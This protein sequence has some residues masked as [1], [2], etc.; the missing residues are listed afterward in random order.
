MTNEVIQNIIT[1]RSIKQYKAQQITDE[2][3]QT[4]LEAG[5]YAPSG[6]GMQSP[7]MVVVQ[8]KDT[9]AQIVRMNAAVMNAT[10]NPYYD[11][12]TVIL[13]LA[14]TD[15]TTYIEDASC[16]L[17]TMMLAAHSIGLASRWIHRE[18]QMFE[19]EEGK[20]LMKKWGVPENYAGIGALA[21]G[22]AD[23]EL[24]EPKERH[25]GRIIY[26]DK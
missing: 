17:D 4:V 15:R 23:C 13:V 21:L 25:K 7:V 9:M 16:V 20:E 8:D 3:L 24:P 2:E 1:R 11:A 5:L 14:P 26:A 12:P 22:Y 10:S 19:T 18:R 6:M